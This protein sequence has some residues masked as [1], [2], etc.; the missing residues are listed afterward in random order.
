MKN[1][2][3][4]SLALCFCASA[5][6]QEAKPVLPLFPGTAPGSQNA[7]QVELRSVVWGED[8]VRNV[9]RPTLTVY[10][11]EPG[12]ATG[13]GVIVAPGG[14][15][16]M[17]SIDSEGEQVAKWLASEGITAFLLTYRLNPTP[18]DSAAF[19]ALLIQTLQPKPG[20]DAIRTLLQTP[21]AQQAMADGL[22]AVRR[23]RE[24]AKE[25]ALEPNRI[26]FLGFSAGAIIAMNLATTYGADSKPN[27]VGSLY[28][29]L[30]AGNAV[31]ADAPPL[32][33]AVAADDPL[34][35]SA[36]TPIFAA[37]Q[38]KGR[39]AELHIFQKGGHGFGL[40]HKGQTS[41]HWNQ[42]FLWWLQSQGLL[43]PPHP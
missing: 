8:R 5:L 35:A 17:L 27:F 6:A 30:P 4:M 16:M 32:F 10:L 39:G 42:E 12:K 40:T 29:A 25:F 3:A 15:F 22:Q 20:E 18:A 13:T 1:L 28:G 33:L 36:S 11:H 34:L 23:V 9:T 26:G 21:G 41:D 19:Q 14:G 2:A 43:I 38:A 37:W 7:T 24:H 31:P